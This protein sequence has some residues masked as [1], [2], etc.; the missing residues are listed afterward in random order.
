[1]NRN[2]CIKVIHKF[3][4]KKTIWVLRNKR[5]AH[6]HIGF[7]SAFLQLF[8]MWRESVSCSMWP[9]TEEA[10]Q[11]AYFF[12][13]LHHF[14]CSRS[15]SFWISLELSEK[16][17]HCRSSLRNHHTSYIQQY[18]REKL[19]WQR[20]DINKWTENK[21]Y[22]ESRLSRSAV[23]YGCGSLS[24]LSEGRAQLHTHQQSRGATVNRYQEQWGYVFIEWHVEEVE[25]RCLHLLVHSCCFT[26]PELSLGWQQIVRSCQDVVVVETKPTGS[27]FFLSPQ[28]HLIPAPCQ[29]F[30][31]RKTRYMGTSPEERGNLSERDE[32]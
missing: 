28:K 4:L 29:L 5:K 12:R 25:K 6:V 26:Q 16:R 2:C 11:P 32:H 31:D 14:L 30:S 9:P 19:S 8:P 20:Q 24:V 7:L 27:I 13:S 1:M 3:T 18:V 10:L 22:A 23:I 21:K 17:C 15:K